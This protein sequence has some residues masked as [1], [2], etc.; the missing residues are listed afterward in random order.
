MK[1]IILIVALFSVPAFSADI[2]GSLHE[3]IEAAGIPINGVSVGKSG[4]KSTWKI[5]FKAEATAQQKTQ[6]AQIV[7]AFDPAVDAVASKT[8][9]QQAREDIE[10]LKARLS[11][12]EAKVTS[13]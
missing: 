13:K 11:A 7:A 2:A 8:E 10:A 3:K 5:D 1:T 6:T 9:L 12:V 4:D